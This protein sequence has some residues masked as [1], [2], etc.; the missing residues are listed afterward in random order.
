MNYADLVSNACSVMIMLYNKLF[1]KVCY[2]P[3]LFEYILKLDRYIDVK[4]F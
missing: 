1:D 3:N 4:F 2:I